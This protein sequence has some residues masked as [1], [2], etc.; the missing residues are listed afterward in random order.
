V[1]G[2]REKSA[3]VPESVT[4]GWLP[5]ALVVTLRTALRVPAAPGVK[6]TPIVQAAPGSSD[7]PHG[8]C[9]V[10]SPLAAPPMVALLIVSGAVPGLLSVTG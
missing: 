9:N 6:I 8:F 1:G 7:A 10:K 3:P 5:A 4:D 2:I